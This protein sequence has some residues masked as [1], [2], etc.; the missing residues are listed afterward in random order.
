[1][2][3]RRQYRF[4]GEDE[5]PQDSP[6]EIVTSLVPSVTEPTD[7]V[8][9]TPLQGAPVRVRVEPQKVSR[10]VFSRR[11]AAWVGGGLA[12]VGLGALAIE[13]GREGAREV[14]IGEQLVQGSPRLEVDH[15][16]WGGSQ[17]RASDLEDASAIFAQEKHIDN[18]ALRR[19]YRYDPKFHTEL[20]ILKE[21]KGKDFRARDVIVVDKEVDPSENT[22]A[23]GDYLP[24]EVPVQRTIHM[25]IPR[26]EY[27]TNILPYLID[28]PNR[29]AGVVTLVDFQQR[30]TGIRFESAA[31]VFGQDALALGSRDLLVLSITLAPT[32][33]PDSFKDGGLVYLGRYKSAFEGEYEFTKGQGLVLGVGPTPFLEPF[34]FPKPLNAIPA[35][36]TLVF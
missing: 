29:G 26:G 11:V 27:K 34:V 1:M 6:P 13:I 28:Y 9:A 12:V 10:R 22:R 33:N 32:E 14:Q 23:H 15:L 20:D 7:L 31:Y 5:V 35:K 2:S 3:D 16:L 21:L 30:V 17:M 36:N 24:G 19:W 25:I 4:G 18:F 8:A